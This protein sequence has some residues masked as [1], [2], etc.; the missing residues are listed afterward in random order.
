[1][2]VRIICCGR[3]KEAYFR[4]ALAEY[5]KRLK[6]YAKIEIAE[7]QD[8]KTPE[9]SSAAEEAQIIAKE[10]RRLLEKIRT[11]DYVIAL[12]I[13]GKACTSENFAE[14]MGN[15]M[16]SGISTIDFVIGGSLGLSDEVLARADEKL[17]F[18]AFTYPH[19]LMRVILAEQ[20]YRSFRILNHEPYHK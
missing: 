12:A 10:G 20:V 1:M 5:T 13:K 9:R 18:S 2:T 11:A 6:R 4:E 3:I 17:S 15:L 8:E 14:H 16:A 7:V 19:Q